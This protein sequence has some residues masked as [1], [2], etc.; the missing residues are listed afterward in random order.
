MTVVCLQGGGEFSPG[1]RAMDRQLL[2]HVPGRVVV[3][4][5]AGEPGRGYRMA[6][7]H[8]VSHFRACGATHVVGAPDVR[9]D[10]AAA[11]KV[12]RSARLLVLP[13]GSPTR[14]LTALR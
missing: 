12:L 9:E 11:L 5:L 4:G 14:L 8:G 1:C 13:G 10:A 6:T 3:T 2:S 7:D